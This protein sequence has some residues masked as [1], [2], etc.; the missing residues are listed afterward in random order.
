MVRWIDD[1]EIVEV[2][3]VERGAAGTI[4]LRKSGG[5]AVATDVVG[6]V[7]SLLSKG[8]DPALI[9]QALSALP[10]AGEAYRAQIASGRG[11]IAAPVEK[12][13]KSWQ[14]SAVAEVMRRLQQMVGKSAD[15]K[16]ATDAALALFQAE[17]DLYDA[18]R[19][20]LL[21]GRG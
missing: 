21:H 2:S 16:A 4:L 6:M 3:L 10:E 5:E 15:T 18:Y 13:E 12:S 20:E 19:S 11:A 14:G 17:P 9:E 8:T 7:Q 1:A